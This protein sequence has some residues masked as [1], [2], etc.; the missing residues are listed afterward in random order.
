M[1]WAAVLMLAMLLAGLLYWQHQRE[2]AVATCL[3]SGGIWN[4]PRSICDPAPARP[5]LQRDL[6]R[7]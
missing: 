3:E 5:I 1:R 6:H 7:S 2:R 4:G